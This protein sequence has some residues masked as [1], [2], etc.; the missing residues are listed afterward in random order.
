MVKVVGGGQGRV[1]GSEEDKVM[2]SGKFKF[3]AEE[4]ERFG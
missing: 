4:V 2:G 1:F 3:A